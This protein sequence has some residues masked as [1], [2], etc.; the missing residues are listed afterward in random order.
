MF[1][2]LASPGALPTWD[3]GK[4]QGLYLALGRLPVKGPTLSKPSTSPDHAQALKEPKGPQVRTHGILPDPTQP[5]HH[6]QSYGRRRSMSF[7]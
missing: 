7:K 5:L 6:S 3:L 4:D 2:E 1:R